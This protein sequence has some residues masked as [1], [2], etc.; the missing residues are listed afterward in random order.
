[1]QI[2]AKVWAQMNGLI[3][4][5]QCLICV[6]MSVF[7]LSRTHFVKKAKLASQ[8]W[9]KMQQEKNGIPGDLEEATVLTFPILTTLAHFGELRLTIT[10]CFVQLSKCHQIHWQEV[11]DKRWTQK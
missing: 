5:T 1:M 7:L 6:R 10:Q 8:K 4:Y 11:Q 9:N 3:V 2:S